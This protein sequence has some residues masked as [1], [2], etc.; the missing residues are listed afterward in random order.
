MNIKQSDGIKIF[1]KVLFIVK[2]DIPK[3][4]EEQYKDWIATCSKRLRTM[5][6]HCQTAQNQKKNVPKWV[7]EVFMDETTE[8]FVKRLRKQRRNRITSATTTTSS[9]HGASKLARTARPNS[10]SSIHQNQAKLQ[11][12]LRWRS[13]RT[14]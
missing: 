4:K 2:K 10:A 8:D 14:A 13:S 9:C 1:T 5:L 12:T 3:M 11:R 7:K 6:R